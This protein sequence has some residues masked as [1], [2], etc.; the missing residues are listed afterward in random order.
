VDGAI[1]GVESFVLRFFAEHA[2]EDRLLVVNLGRDLLLEPAPEPLLAPPEGASWVVMWA[3]E[4]PRYGGSGMPTW[5]AE[6]CWHLQG[7]TAVVLRP[8]YSRE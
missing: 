4:D 8:K 3:S 5:P 7:E 6:G 2:D 1:L